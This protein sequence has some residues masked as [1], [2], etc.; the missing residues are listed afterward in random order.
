MLSVGMFQDM[1]KLT[2]VICCEGWNK[3]RLTGMYRRTHHPDVMEL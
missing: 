2:P 3:D 1:W